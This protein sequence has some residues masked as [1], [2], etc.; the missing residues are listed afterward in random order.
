MDEIKTGS[1]EKPLVGTFSP[2]STAPIA[3]PKALGGFDYIPVKIMS[4]LALMNPP[5]RCLWLWP[6]ATAVACTYLSGLDRRSNPLY[7]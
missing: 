3:S 7:T 6:T 5:Y 2:T 4:H 1:L